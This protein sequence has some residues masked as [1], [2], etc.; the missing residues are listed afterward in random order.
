MIKIEFSA[1]DLRPLVTSVVADVLAAAERLP[2]DRLGYNE[3]E[4]ASL[5]GLAKH[6][7]RDL[8]LRGEA[9]ATKLG[10][11]WVYARTELMRLLSTEDNQ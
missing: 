2:A 8:R 7:L 1:D 9:K 4:A 3:A 11:G 10:K 5:L 6:Q